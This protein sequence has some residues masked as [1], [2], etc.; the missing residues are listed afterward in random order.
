MVGQ[1]VSGKHTSGLGHTSTRAAR[2][3]TESRAHTPL[4]PRGTNS[5]KP[6]V[7]AVKGDKGEF[8][9]YHLTSRRNYS[10]SVLEE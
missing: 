1:L 4:V 3:V 7:R 2:V 10:L 8:D 9:I 5:E 6:F